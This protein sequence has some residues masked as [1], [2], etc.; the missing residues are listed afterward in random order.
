MSTELSFIYETGKIRV[1]VIDNE[2][3]FVAK[4]VCDILELNNV[5]MATN[6]LE[7]DE[8]GINYIDTLGGR[9]KMVCVSESG[10]YAL[11]FTSSKPEAKAFRRWVTKEVLPSIRKT[12][13]YEAKRLPTIEEMLLPPTQLQ[14]WKGNMNRICQGDKNYK[15]ENAIIFRHLTGFNPEEYKR[16]NNVKKGKSAINHLRVVDPAKAYAYAWLHAFRD[17]GHRIADL[18][19]ARVADRYEDL[20]HSCA[21]LIER[22]NHNQML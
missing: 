15:K 8:K 4:D 10:L 22:A 11:I 6:R 5:S 1:A 16:I 12:G 17:S 14:A 18:F 2:P 20:Y 21:N 13:K 9:Q 7:E 19:E 3:W